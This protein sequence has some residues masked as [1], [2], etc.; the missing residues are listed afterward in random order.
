MANRRN[1][2]GEL[3]NMMMNNPDE[4][5]EITIERGPQ[6]E[7][8][9][10]AATGLNLSTNG[11]KGSKKTESA[12]G[13]L[14]PEEAA[15]FGITGTGKKIDLEEESARQA[16][17]RVDKILESKSK[18]VTD[19]LDDA[20]AGEEE[21]A[22]RIGNAMA[23][24]DTRKGIMQGSANDPAS[25]VDYVKPLGDD[26]VRRDQEDN[27]VER[28][29]L[30]AGDD[31]LMPSYSD[32]DE[33]VTPETPDSVNTNPRPTV[34]DDAEQD[35]KNFKEWLK[36]MDTVQADTADDSIITTVREKYG[37]VESIANK[38]VAKTNILSDSAFMNAVTKYKKDNFR[39]VSV[40]LVNSGF[41]VNMVGTGAV[42]LNLLYNNT[43]EGISAVEYEIERMK[44]I[45][46]G[47]IGTSPKIDPNRLRNF[48]HFTDYQLLAWAHVA[49]TLDKVELVK[50]CSECG[51]DFHVVVQTKDLLINTPEIIERTKLIRASDN[52]DDL[53]LMSRDKKIDTI[54]GFQVIAGH[55]SYSDYIQHLSD[56]KTM[57]DQLD[58]TEMH[59]LRQLQAILAFIRKIYLPN[60]VSTSTFQQKYIALTMLSDEELKTVNKEINEMTK[61]II[62][63]KFGIRKV[64]CPYCGK[65]HVDSDQDNLADLLFFHIMV[66]RWMNSIEE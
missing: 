40:P 30:S 41:I 35:D 56:I 49:A 32:E 34:T 59:R 22:E 54:N 13:L 1:V 18:Q 45:F 38:A 11:K 44:V 51:R 61:K 47:I 21:R 29:N 65:V 64:K 55:P 42:D 43:D 5:P 25:K 50:E 36:N 27:T 39:T 58:R 26:E 14:T 9:L 28:D 24:A 3:T 31:D 4:E 8:V 48:I 12:K 7:E 62:T 57:T 66:S 6:P 60:G 63:P 16:N 2:A 46:K 10:R 33:A 19:L 15:Q 17:A 52:V 20:L 23:D 37:T 53:S